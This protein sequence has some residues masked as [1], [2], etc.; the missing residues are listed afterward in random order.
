MDSINYDH[1]L[2]EPRGGFALA[3]MILGGI[4]ILSVS[5]FYMSVMFGSLG[6]LFAFL[7]KKG[8]EKFRSANLFG[9]ISSLS[10]LVMGLA[11]SIMMIISAKDLLQPENR[12]QLD[13]IF[14]A[15]YGVNFDEYIDG[16]L[17]EDFDF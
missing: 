2:A 6:L 17:G 12:A 16:L 5:T 13:N 3:S 11:F 14:E 1:P 4:S 9:F 15:A 8:K 10:G 7:A